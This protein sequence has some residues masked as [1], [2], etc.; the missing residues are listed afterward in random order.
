MRAF[1]ISEPA[2]SAWVRPAAR[3]ACLTSP[4]TGAACARSRATA[5]RARLL[6]VAI[7]FAKRVESIPCAFFGISEY[8]VAGRRVNRYERGREMVLT[9][10]REGQRITRRQHAVLDLVARGYAN[11]Q[12]AGELAISEGAV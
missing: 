2:S 10:P 3:R 1:V 4:P 7:P 9:E 11:K 6:T 12:I 5:G 8:P